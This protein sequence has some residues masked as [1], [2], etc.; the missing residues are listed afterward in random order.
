MILKVLALVLLTS[1]GG[2]SLQAATLGTESGSQ[3]RWGFTGSSS[4]GSWSFNLENDALAYVANSNQGGRSSIGAYAFNLQPGLSGSYANA[5]FRL[6][7]GDLSVGQTLSVLSNYLWNGGVRGIEFLKGDAGLF[8]FEHGDADPNTGNTDQLVLRG[9]GI[10]DTV[11][12]TNA[13]TNSYRLQVTR[14]P[15]DLVVE[16][17]F[18]N[19][20]ILE[21]VLSETVVNG[22]KF[23][24]G[25]V[26]TPAADQ[27][28]YGLFFNDVTVG[29]P[30]PSPSLLIASGLLALVALRRVGRSR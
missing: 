19:N 20:K 13:F 27:P 25:G 7:G 17:I 8:R 15:T 12:S 26:N 29:V 2:F 24:V 22:L 14:R 9:P 23:Y 10:S 11:V 30:E 16:A 4:L 5:T 18:N 1:A 28:N 3:Y 6:N 21:T